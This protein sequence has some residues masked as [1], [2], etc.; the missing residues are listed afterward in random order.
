MVFIEMEN[1]LEAGKDASPPENMHLALIVMGAILLGVSLFQVL[2]KGKQ[3]RRTL[4][5]KM[6]GASATGRGDEESASAPPSPMAAPEM[7][8]RPF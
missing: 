4:D 2:L 3:T 5:E 1:G 8:A 6:G 7:V